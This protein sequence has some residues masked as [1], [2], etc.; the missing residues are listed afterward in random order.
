[1]K[2][3]IRDHWR[4]FAAIIGL[5]VIAGAVSSVI[6]KNQRFRFPIIQDK[7]VRMYAELANAQAVTPGQGQ[8]VEVA[9]VKIGLIANIELRDG[10]AL[11]GLDIEKRFDDVIHTEGTTALLRPR[12]GLKDM[13]L[14]V[15]PGDPDSPVAEEGF[16]IPS[17]ST[18]TDVDL[19]EFLAQL[20]VDT[21]E[22]L[23]LL[24]GGAAR[25]LK[26][27]GMD[28][29]ELFRRFGPTVRDLRRVN[30]AVAAEREGLKDAINGLALL[31][32]ELAG[33]DEELA[34]LVDS[35]ATVFEAFASEDENLSATVDRLPGALRATTSALGHVDR[36]ADE[37]G[38]AA[39]A[40]GP[41]FQAL[42]RANGVV[43]PVARR[44]TPI[45]GDE[46]RPFVSEARPLVS[47]LRSASRGLATSLPD[48]TGSFVRINH[49]F[50]MLGFN[51][52]GREAADVAGRDEGYLFWLAWV[53][54]QTA[55]LQNIDDGNGPMRP[56]FLT[57]TCQTLTELVD[58]QP[59]L[60]FLMGLTGLLSEQCNNPQTLSIDVPRAS[61]QIAQ[62]TRDSIRADELQ[63]QRLGVT[64]P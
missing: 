5:L 2:R 15:D 32:S 24:I 56:V 26:G 4:D 23:Q 11:V 16:T 57:G 9:G 55:N 39:D 46:I 48:L 1:M 44:L 42:D 28:L 12:T 47:D 25:G 20:D 37:L 54:H 40:L 29:A 33:K 43:A 17:R 45:I 21:R 13:F 35:S 38:P 52:A 3:A 22:H 7:P 18:L 64:A 6:L 61:R 62:E 59:E 50:N 34:G 36:F 30:T 27:R 14:Q 58:A 10:K 60:E 51:S 8:T 19:D 41:T 53:A 49:L 63:A 31:T